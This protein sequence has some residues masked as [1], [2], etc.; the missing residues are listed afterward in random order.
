MNEQE[1]TEGAGKSREPTQSGS[2][3]GTPPREMC[4]PSPL[5]QIR[6][7]AYE[8]W[9]AAGKPEGIAIRFWLEAEKELRERRG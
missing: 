8:K 5:Q 2:P 7:R 6:Q 1:R 3:E 9:E 4:S